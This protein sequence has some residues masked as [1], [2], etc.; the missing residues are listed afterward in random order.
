MVLI[1]QPTVQELS[2]LLRYTIQQMKKQWFP[3]PPE[4]LQVRPEIH[5]YHLYRSIPISDK[6][7]VQ[8]ESQ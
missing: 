8:Q 4:H 5:L 2:Q 6:G 1:Q 7:Q 3:D